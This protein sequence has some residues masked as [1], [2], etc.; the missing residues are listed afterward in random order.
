[1]VVICPFLMIDGGECCLLFEV[2]QSGLMVGLV[3]FVF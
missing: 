2:F 3:L 1:M